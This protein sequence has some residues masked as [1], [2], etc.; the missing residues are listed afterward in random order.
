M[1]NFLLTLSYFIFSSCLLAQTHS[2]SFD[3]I[4]DYVSIADD[5]TLNFGS[6]NFTVEFWVLRESVTSNFDNSQGVGKWNTGANPG[7]NEW[8]LGFATSANNN[9]GAFDIEVDN[10]IYEVETVEDLPLN[11]WVHLAGVRE[12]NSLK[13]YV[14]GILK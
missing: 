3:G 4:D 1:K 14:D 5:G 10:T 6:G 13:I 7:S 8:A 11:S 2:L 12:E 9:H